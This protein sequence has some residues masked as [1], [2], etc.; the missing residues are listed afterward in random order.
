MAATM[1]RLHI[2]RRSLAYSQ[3]RRSSVVSVERVAISNDEPNSLYPPIK[4]KYPPGTWGA[5][6]PKYAWLWDKRR[7]ESLAIPDVQQRIAALCDKEM[8]HLVVK[9][10]DERPR[11]LD[12][13]KYITKTHVMPGLPETYRT[14]VDSS[15][16]D[17]LTALLSPLICDSIAV[18]MDQ[19]QRRGYLKHF[20]KAGNHQESAAAHL[21]LRTILCS[22]SA[23][24]SGQFPHLL[25]M[26]YD[27]NVN[28]AAT[29]DRH[30]I[31]RSRRRMVHPEWFTSDI[32]SDQRV[33]ANTSADFVLRSD[34]PL[35]EFVSHDSGPSTGTEIPAINFA[36]HVYGQ[37]MIPKEKST[38]E[39]GYV[40]GDPCEFGLMSVLNTVWSHYSAEK[41]GENHAQDARLGQG[42][43]S[44]FVWL[45]AQAH[46]QGFNTLVDMTY[47]LTTQT[48]LTDGQ[49]WQFLAY[50]LNTMEL[51]KDNEGNHRANLCWVSDEAKLYAEVVEGK[52]HGFNPD[53]LRQLIAFLALAPAERPYDLRPTLPPTGDEPKVREQYIPVKTEEVIVVE[54]EKYIVE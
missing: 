38:V 37:P 21:L 6:E 11:T 31:K 32:V 25:T 4:T 42:V 50:Q 12:F 33:K 3:K 39:A 19:L 17:E 2:C 14:A 52:V 41:Y 9:V 1:R 36:P 54:E 7:E 51:W 22:L 34:Q 16:L 48:V 40:C 5:M 8:K 53:V 30:G 45:A 44:S 15:L 29:W 28:L 10:K 20:M 18:E 47:P 27:E 13:K 23:Q 43:M 26:Q 46:N 24:L 49:H 35:P